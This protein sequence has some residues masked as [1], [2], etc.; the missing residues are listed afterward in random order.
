M[1]VDSRIRNAAAL[2][3]IQAPLDRS[4]QEWMISG[5][6]SNAV[7]R[8]LDLSTVN[9]PDVHGWTGR[10]SDVIMR[11]SELSNG[12]INTTTAH[13][14]LVVRMFALMAEYEAALIRERTQARGRRG[15][16]KPKMTPELIGKAH[17]GCMTPGGSP[18]PRSPH[19]AGS[20]P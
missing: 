1:S 11:V 13:G 4:S 3:E 15:G 7:P 9:S 18:W 8:C 20:H 5:V 19:P 10:A 6:I 2:E 17:V 12:L 14:A 16:R